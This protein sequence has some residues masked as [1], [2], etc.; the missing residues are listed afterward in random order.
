MVVKFEELSIKLLLF[1]S[2]KISRNFT[3]FCTVINLLY[4]LILLVLDILGPKDLWHFQVTALV[5]Q[6]SGVWS[7]LKSHSF[8]R[9]HGNNLSIYMNYRDLQSSPLL[10][11]PE[12][13]VSKGAR[14]PWLAP[15]FRP[16]NPLVPPGLAI[17]RLLGCRSW[18]RRAAL[19]G[20]LLVLTALSGVGHLGS[21]PGPFPNSTDRALQAHLLI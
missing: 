12:S 20:L 17:S 14:S 16:V 10:R 6:H 1:T 15:H 5:I 2:Y 9:K 19:G 11:R 7:I 4:L 18:P 8:I 3:L 13:R 21:S